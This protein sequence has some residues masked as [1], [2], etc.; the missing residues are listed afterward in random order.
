MTEDSMFPDFVDREGAIGDTCEVVM[1]DPAKSVAL[2]Q[3]TPA[4]TKKRP[5]RRG[6]KAPSGN[7]RGPLTAMV[8][9]SGM[10]VSAYLLS[11]SESIEQLMSVVWANESTFF[12]GILAVELSA[13]GYEAHR[14]M[15]TI[16]RKC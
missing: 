2:K 10:I 6:E 5:S 11:H 4:R 7:S 12:F 16:R 8:L 3:T 13:I 15:R 14:I 1:S 9:G